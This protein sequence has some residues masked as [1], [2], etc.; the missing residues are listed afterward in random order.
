MKGLGYSTRS[1]LLTQHPELQTIDIR[2]KK[3]ENKWM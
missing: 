2:Y 3:G 1:K